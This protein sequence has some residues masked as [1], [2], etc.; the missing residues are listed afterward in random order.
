MESTLHNQSIFEFTKLHPHYNAD[1]YRRVP[2]QDYLNPEQAFDFNLDCGMLG[3]TPCEKAL[4]NLKLAGIKIA[5]Q[6]KFKKQI[7]VEAV[8]NAFWGNDFAESK[9]AG[10]GKFEFDF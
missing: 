4:D 2:E 1:I 9:P 6:I 10:F 3:Q 7:K 5:K 8:F